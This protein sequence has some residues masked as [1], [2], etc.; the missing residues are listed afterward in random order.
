VNQE[1]TG[2]AVYYSRVPAPTGELP[3]A[4]RCQVGG[5]PAKHVALVDTACPWCVLPPGIAI[6]LGL[7][8]ETAPGERLHTRFGTLAGELIRLPV[9][10]VADEGEPAEVEA[11][12]FLSPEW[13]G[14]L[15]IGWTGCLERLR[16]AFDPRAE[17]ICFAEY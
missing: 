2:R 11:T 9:T 3:V 17:A 13:P 14:P 15:V 6:D 1:F 10:F 5:N 4:I 12:W 7:S 8:L 16:F